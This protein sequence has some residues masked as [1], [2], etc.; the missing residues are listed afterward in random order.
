MQAKGR[1]AINRRYLGLILGALTGVVVLIGIN[2]PNTDWMHTPG[3]MNVGHEEL[4]CGQCHLKAQGTLRQQLQANMWHLLGVRDSNAAI[5]HEEVGNDDCL[6]CHQRPKDLHPVFRFFEP[7]YAEAR[8]NIQP[9]QCNSCHREHS[10][11]RVT[12]ARNYCQQC[13]EK[14]N[15]KKDPL[16][17]SHKTLVDKKR[18]NSCLECHDFHGNHRMTVATDMTKRIS[19]HAVDSYFAGGESPYSKEK[20]YQAKKKRDGID[21]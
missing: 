1:A 16:K 4:D 18:W 8:K 17:I 21:E 13:H 15:L 3:P 11:K 19:A 9:H 2:L 6:A 10:G 7:R 5:G 12:I 20:R 14:L